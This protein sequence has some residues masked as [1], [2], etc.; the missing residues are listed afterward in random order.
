MKKIKMLAKISLKYWLHHKRRLFTLMLTL[1]LGVSALCCTAL[2]VRS[3]KDAV[4][5]EELRLLGNYDIPVYGITEETAEIFR[6]EKDIAELGVQYELGYVL[7][8]TGA[9]HYAAAFA[10]EC[11]Q[12]IYHMT[13]TR[14]RY[15]ECDDEVAMDISVAKALGI[16]PYP[17]EKIKLSL[18]SS[19]EKHLTDKEYTLCGVFEESN[20]LVYGGWLRY[21]TGINEGSYNMP[22]VYFYV[23]EKGIFKSNAATAF[24]QTDLKNYTPLLK[25]LREISDDTMQ[26][27]VINGRRFAYSYILGISTTVREK[28]GDN[29]FSSLVKAI[30][31]GDV[32]KDFYS[33]IVMPLL[34]IIILVVVILSV[35]GVAKNITSDKQEE[36][37]VL[38]SLGLEQRQLNL[39]VFC[40]FTIIALLCIAVGLLLGCLAHICMID[41]LNR[42]YDLKLMHGFSCIDH[43]KAVTN[44]PFILS[45]A[46]MIFCVEFSLFFSLRSIN[47]KTPIQI[48]SMDK[49]TGYKKRKEKPA[50]KYKGWKRLLIRR[51]TLKNR[52]IM[53]VSLLVMSVAVFGYTYFHALSDKENIELKAQKENSGLG[54]WDYSAE[55]SE[56]DQMYT[57]NIENQHSHGVDQKDYNALKEK[58]YVKDSFG[59]IVNRSTRLTFAENELDESALKAL[60][61]YDIKQFTKV[62]P[63]TENELDRSLK[64]GEDTM[65][66]KI[67]YERTDHIYS[68]PTVGLF[69]EDLEKLNK[70]VVKG[71]INIERIK[72]G[73][74]VILVMTASSKDRF[75]SLFKAQEDLPLSDIV[76]NDAQESLDFG[77][78]TLSQ[79]GEPVYKKKVP[80]ENGTT[81][82]LT[83]YALGKRKDLNT[84][85]GAVIV[86]DTDEAK[87][88]MAIAD[89][90]RYG[91]NA[92]CSIDTYSSWGLKDSRLTDV[93]IK[94]KDDSFVNEADEFWYGIMSSSKG[95][96]SNS[97]AEISA[98]MNK[99]TRKIMSIYYCMIIIL[100]M[101][102]SVMISISLYT[103]IRIRSTK[104]A[105]L[106]ACGM[107]TSQIMFMVWR[108][109]IIYPVF[110]AV[111]SIA[112]V[113][114]CQQFFKFIRKK[115]ESGAWVPDNIP[116]EDGMIQPKVVSWIKS[117]PYGRNLYDY[118]VARTIIF[119]FIIYLTIIMLITLT[120]VMII[121]RQ[122]IAEE[123]EKSSF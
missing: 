103:D 28:Y 11:S 79:L 17:G 59:K 122:S 45:S 10:D 86:L 82:E 16:K 99:G 94:L 62:N 77:N 95:M 13:C 114:L 102:A 115:V 22:G 89:N 73:N 58:P 104:F 27:D 4:L 19:D 49:S 61:D 5:E 111:I 101:T 72:G 76:L 54:Y 97:T 93:S 43:I 2:L 110:G 75:L 74:E 46:A 36:F 7:N 44:D 68:C 30:K 91:L 106:R 69:D 112:P 1:V 48:F 116:T 25:R 107:S 53:I 63:N 20:S 23:S 34:T 87:K 60:E 113:A 84:K 55:K 108:Q 88:Y 67:G 42:L 92:F 109:N 98:N 120:Q 96:I 70:F 100:V 52:G 32:I 117:V 90:G 35:V 38:R 14:G 8:P 40:D 33:S 64:E 41:I 50:G 15:P 24:I 78:L 105:M 39:Y 12:E 31:N 29:S 119:A 9:K 57:F 83:S 123:I 51:I 85:I 21:P 6:Q 66:E 118:N 81:V 3:E 26:Y 18:Y 56:T 71:E 65:V 37:A 121:R 47:G 80:A